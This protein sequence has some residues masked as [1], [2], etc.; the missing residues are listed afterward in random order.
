VHSPLSINA[1]PGPGS[2]PILPSEVKKAVKSTYLPYIHVP[3][4]Q[5]VVC[6]F[7][8]HR[9]NN[10]GFRGEYEDR[11]RSDSVIP[12]FLLLLLLL[13]ILPL[14]LFL[15]LLLLLLLLPSPPHPPPPPP[16]SRLFPSCFEQAEGALICIRL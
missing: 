12:L 3:T 2:A 10:R 7:T 16:T 8:Q 11:I 5:L 4:V 14:L 13:L 15:L 6:T 1:V 9:V